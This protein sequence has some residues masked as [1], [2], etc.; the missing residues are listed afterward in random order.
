MFIVACKCIAISR[1]LAK[2]KSGKWIS[3]KS[4][5]GSETKKERGNGKRKNSLTHFSGNFTQPFVDNTADCADAAAVCTEGAWPGK[6]SLRSDQVQYL[7]YTNQRGTVDRTCR[8]NP[9][10][11]EYMLTFRIYQP[12]PPPVKLS[13]LPSFFECSNL[14]ALEYTVADSYYANSAERRRR[15]LIGHNDTVRCICVSGQSRWLDEAGRWKS[16]FGDDDSD[17]DDCCHDDDGGSGGGSAT[18]P[19]K[20]GHDHFRESSSGMG[21]GGSDGH[22][23]D[24][25]GPTKETSTS[26]WVITGSI[27]GTVRA[28]G[29][30]DAVPNDHQGRDGIIYAHRQFIPEEGEVDA[31]NAVCISD[32][33]NFVLSGGDAEEVSAFD[34]QDGKGRGNRIKRF[35]GKREGKLQQQRQNWEGDRTIYHRSAVRSICMIGTCRPGDDTQGKGY[36]VITGTA[37]GMIR[38]YDFE[39]ENFIFTANTD[40]NN[41]ECHNMRVPL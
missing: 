10:W 3:G 28:Y 27:D 16:G 15:K 8:R 1:T 33:N 31:I 2:D 37:D 35:G 5:R 4:K 20:H 13:T 25:E 26:Y 32:N 29:V 40:A 6:T 19:A 41:P 39:T 34:F 21:A 30:S 11:E 12:L 24:D 18:N 14:N 36:M 17:H 22:K 9:K 23:H 38:M 7:K